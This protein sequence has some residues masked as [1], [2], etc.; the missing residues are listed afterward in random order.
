MTQSIYLENPMEWL[1]SLPYNN[2]V[3]YIGTTT[4]E[5]ETQAAETV[6]ISNEDPNILRYKLTSKLVRFFTHFLTEYQILLLVSSVYVL[7]VFFISEV[8]LEKKDMQRLDC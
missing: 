6:Q 2:N 5:R 7:Y 4:S 1:T 8:L 3:V